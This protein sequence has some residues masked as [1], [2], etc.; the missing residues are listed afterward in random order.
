MSSK[1]CAPV[2]ILA[3]AP[4]IAGNEV[5]TLLDSA[6]TCTVGD[7]NGVGAV[8]LLLNEPRRGRGTYAPV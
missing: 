5:R 7:L 3:V 6:G 2:K 1:I 8:R 4:L